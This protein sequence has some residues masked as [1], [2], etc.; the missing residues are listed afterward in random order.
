MTL[1]Q[2]PEEHDVLSCQHC[3]WQDQLLAE[4]HLGTGPTCEWVLIKCLKKG[5]Y[6]GEAI[7]LILLITLL[8]PVLGQDRVLQ[9]QI[10]VLTP[11]WVLDHVCHHG[12]SLLQVH[13][14]TLVP[15]L[16]PVLPQPGLIK[17]NHLPLAVRDGDV[18][19]ALVC[20]INKKIPFTRLDDNGSW[21][22]HCSLERGRDSKGR[23]IQMTAENVCV[24]GGAVLRQTA[25]GEY[26]LATMGET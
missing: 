19:V 10:P 13:H 25:R 16:C 3:L 9:A 24:A 14:Q 5:E 1:L 15:V 18:Q 20:V 17:L 23:N 11:V 8:T 6:K 22:V 12:L 2:L 21:K 4:R 7:V 26:L